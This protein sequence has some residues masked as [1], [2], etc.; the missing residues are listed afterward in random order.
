LAAQLCAAVRSGE[1][2]PGDRLPSERCLAALLNIHRNTIA[3]VYAELDRLGLVRRTPGSGTFVRSHLRQ[4]AN[5]RDP[6]SFG[7]VRGFADFLEAQR[8]LGRTAAELDR[9]LGR[10]SARS[11]DPRVAVVEPEAGLRQLFVEEISGAMPDA[12]V[13]GWRP[14]DSRRLM[15]GGF[16]IV[17][18]PDVAVQLPVPDPA[19]ADIMVLRTTGARH[20]RRAVRSLGSGEVVAL[21]TVSSCLRRHARELLSSELSD[22]IGFASPAPDQKDEVERVARISSLVLVDTLCAALLHGA[23]TPLSRGRRASHMLVN[24]IC[25]VWL[26]KLVRYLGLEG[27]NCPTNAASRNLNAHLA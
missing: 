3:A 8:N 10:W 24:V 2:N 22:R 13:T 6:S 17:A 23:S 1:L 18:R 7:L 20:L 5:D 16:C 21:L 12:E 9:L 11:V 26:G 14:G 4:S 15:A 19:L 27:R 25:P